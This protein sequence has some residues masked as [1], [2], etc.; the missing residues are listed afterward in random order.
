VESTSLDEY[1]RV[2]EVNLLGYISGTQCA[3]ELMRPRG[4]GGII[5]VSSIVAR[6]G[7]AYNSAYSASKMALDGIA[8]ALRT[9]LWGSDI[10]TDGDNLERPMQDVPRERDGWA[11]RGWQGWTVGETLRVLPL[12]SAAPAAL[13][14]LAVTALRRRLRR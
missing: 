12:E 3:L 6:R 10:P 2:L 13:A 9:E 4:A 8:Q 7:A 5:L 1:R 11:R 14:V